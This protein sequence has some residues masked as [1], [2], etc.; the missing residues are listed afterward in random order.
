MPKDSTIKHCA[1]V[2]IHHSRRYRDD[3][4]YTRQIAIGR[5]TLQNWLFTLRFHLRAST[6]HGSLS[7]PASRMAGSAVRGFTGALSVG[8]CSPTE[9]VLGGPRVGFEG[10]VKLSRLSL[11]RLQTNIR[12]LLQVISGEMVSFSRRFNS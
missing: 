7:Q 8:P 6:D 5:T 2:K 1:T 11:N 4:G 10:L 3:I 12:C 9:T